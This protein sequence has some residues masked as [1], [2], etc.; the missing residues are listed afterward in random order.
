MRVCGKNMRQRSQTTPRRNTDPRCSPEGEHVADCEC[1]SGK[2]HRYYNCG[3]A[4]KPCPSVSIIAADAE[5]LVAGSFL[6][7]H[8]G[9]KVRAR[10]WQEGSDHSV[11]L[12]QTTKTIEALREDRALGLFTSPE[13]QEMY[14]QQM[15]ALV[16]KRD[17]LAALPIVRA[18]WVEVRPTGRTRRCGLRPASRSVERC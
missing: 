5:E 14:R 12:E 6:E 13:D 4:P 15:A 9:R 18:G 3:R 2:T 1:F 7:F 8:G 16:A 11:E 10:V 17:T